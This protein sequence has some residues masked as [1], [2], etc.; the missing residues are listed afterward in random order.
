MFHK[1]DKQNDI[2]AMN[3]KKN[4]NGQQYGHL[5]FLEEKNRHVP[6]R[7]YYNVGAHMTGKWRLTLHKNG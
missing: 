1:N 4:A 2:V 3:S 5:V 7:P 6:F